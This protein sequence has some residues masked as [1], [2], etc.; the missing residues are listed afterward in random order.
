MILTLTERIDLYCE[1]DFV[2]WTWKGAELEIGNDKK[3]DKYLAHFLVFLI[4]SSSRISFI[5]CMS[6][7]A[8]P[9]SPNP[10]FWS[11]FVNFFLNLSPSLISWRQNER[12]KT[13]AFMFAIFRFQKELHHPFWK[14]HNCVEQTHHVVATIKAFYLFSCWYLI[15]S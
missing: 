10:N 4:F 14:W 1:K 7:F 9:P 13:N 11:T 5:L 15:F 2:G 6:T 8:E 3:R 12:E